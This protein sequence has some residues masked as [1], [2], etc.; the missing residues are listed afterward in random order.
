MQ[1]TFSKIWIPIVLLVLI[2]AGIFAWQYFGVSEKKVSEEIVK[3]EVADWQTYRNEEFGFEV[4][5][6]KDII[7]VSR[8]DKKIVMIHSIPFKH[9]DPCDFKGGASPLKELTDFDIS[10]EV[11]DKNLREAV[12]AKE[13]SYLV[14]NFLL[15][16]KLKI[17]PNFI[18]EISIDSLK[19]YR[20]TSGI[21]GCGKYT[22]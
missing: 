15:D 4:K 9:L 8:D 19:G 3:D 16:H 18:D 20:I 21:E 5:Y 1:L 13:G 22:Y 12:I 11:V 10:I 2:A 6:P 7:T 14:S 17:T